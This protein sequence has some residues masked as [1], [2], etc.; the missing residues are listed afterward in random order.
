MLPVSFFRI[1][2]LDGGMYTVCHTHMVNE[3][4][5]ESP[6]KDEDTAWNVTQNPV[7]GTHQTT[8]LSR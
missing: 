3:Q 1:Y 7:I 2:L 4:I 8:D 5:R 6:R